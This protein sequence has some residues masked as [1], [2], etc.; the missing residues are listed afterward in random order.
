MTE[1]GL[2]TK[3]SDEQLIVK[4]DE[5]DAHLLTDHRWFVCKTGHN[6][7]V[8]R[9][10]MR[11]KVTRRFLLHREIMHPPEGFVVD[12]INGDALDN[13]RINLRIATHAQNIRNKKT[14]SNNTSGYKGVVDTKC[15]LRIR[16]FKAQVKFEGKRH[17]VGYYLTAKEAAHAYNVKAKEL[18]GE[19]A[20]LN[21]I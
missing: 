6:Y 7:Y 2:K 10:E 3:H 5:G 9:A 14:P 4:I 20:R 8:F 12:H 13:R 1:I 18:F 16:K 15:E 19:F 21:V 17:H 11:N